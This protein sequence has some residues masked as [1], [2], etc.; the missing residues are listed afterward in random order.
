[1]KC[2][3]SFGN[4][5]NIIQKIQVIEEKEEEEINT[6]VEVETEMEIGGKK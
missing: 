2:G 5:V 3:R 4:E 1:M 6:K